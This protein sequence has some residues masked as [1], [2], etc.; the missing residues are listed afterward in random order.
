M[1]MQISSLSTQRT[2]V[3]RRI[4]SRQ[5]ELQDHRRQLVCG[6]RQYLGTPRSV[7]HAFLAGFLLDQSRAMVPEGPS[8]LKLLMPF[9][10]RFL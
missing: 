3:R 1:I 5:Q 4:A 8:P 6:A 2:V 9:L 10:I 7:V